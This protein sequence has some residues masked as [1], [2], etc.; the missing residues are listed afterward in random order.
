MVKGH[1]ET[2]CTDMQIEKKIYAK[3]R[4][5]Q[6]GRNLRGT[7]DTHRTVKTKDTHKG[8]NRKTPKT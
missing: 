2:R 8:A 6:K 1:A 7:K 4:N 3:D 5:K